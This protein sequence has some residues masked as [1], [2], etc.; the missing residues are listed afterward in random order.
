MSYKSLYKVT[1]WIA[2]FRRQERKIREAFP[3]EQFKQCLDKDSF[4]MRYYNP[5]WVVTDHGNI[6]SLWSERPLKVYRNKVGKKNKVG[7]YSVF[8]YCYRNNWYESVQKNGAKD[9]LI[10]APHR[11]VANYFC[12]KTVI[13][14]YGEANVEVHHIFGYDE[15]AE[16]TEI[17]QVSQIQYTLK[18]DHI[19]LNALQKGT[20][21]S[22]LEHN[23]GLKH[24][25][26]L[27]DPYIQKIIQN[28]KRVD[29]FQNGLKMIYHEDGTTDLQVIIGGRRTVDKVT[30]NL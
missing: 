12:D 17:N 26:N 18:G 29:G 13:D 16:N 21:L 4:N 7:E 28:A 6:W 8:K 11:L 25:L 9:M 2:E 22:N 15:T 5:M 19:L 30:Q 14:L 20:E 27:D 1:D 23:K 3:G 24:K 10:I